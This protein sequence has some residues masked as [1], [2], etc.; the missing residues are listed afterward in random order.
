MCN[1]LNEMPAG[2]E[3]VTLLAN[4]M[5]YVL[6][7]YGPLK[8]PMLNPKDGNNQDLLGQY[9]GIITLY[10]KAGTHYEAIDT[11]QIAK[12]HNKNFNSEIINKDRIIS[13]HQGAALKNSKVTNTYCKELSV[14]NSKSLG[15]WWKIHSKPKLNFE[16]ANHIMNLALDC[17]FECPDDLF[18]SDERADRF[19]A[20][21]NHLEEKVKNND[22]K[23]FEKIEAIFNNQKSKMKLGA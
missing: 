7:V 5:G 6:E 9:L 15:K 13:A 10:N 3:L 18:N 23:T 19:T 1:P 20:L 11:P 12:I 4:K 17:N 22:T 14:L 16:K 2:L 21:W 8:A